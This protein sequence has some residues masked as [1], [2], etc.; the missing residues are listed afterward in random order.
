MTEVGKE[1]VVVDEAGNEGLWLLLD[2]TLGVRC[3]SPVGANKRENEP[4]PISRP[5]SSLCN[6][7]PRAGW[8]SSWKQRRAVSV[9]NIQLERSSS[10]MG[11]SEGNV[12]SD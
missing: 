2:V 10:D 4:L 1:A 3:C 12:E 5:V 9:T 8:Y 7:R 6:Q 11:Y